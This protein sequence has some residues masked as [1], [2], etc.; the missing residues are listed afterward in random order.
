MWEAIESNRRRSVLI[1]AGVAAAAARARGAAIAAVYVPTGHGAL[2]GALGALVL[3]ALLVAG[4]LRQGESVLL[5][6]A[7]AHALEKEDCPRLWNVVE[8]MSIAAGLPSS[9]RIHLLE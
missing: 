7:G 4:A 3:W 5:A 8:E 6:G 1:L 9:P 2:F